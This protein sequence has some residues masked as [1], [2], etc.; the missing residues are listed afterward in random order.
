MIKVVCDFCGKEVDDRDICDEDGHATENAMIRIE[1]DG[2]HCRD[3][4]DE[5]IICVDCY[6]KIKNFIEQSVKKIDKDKDSCK[7]TIAEKDESFRT[8][9]RSDLFQ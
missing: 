7:T 3:Y 9:N 5:Y 2:Y 6:N 1:T 8:I 4:G